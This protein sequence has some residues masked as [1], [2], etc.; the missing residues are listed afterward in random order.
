MLPDLSF[1]EWL[2]WAACASVSDFSRVFAGVSV[3]RPIQPSPVNLFLYTYP[4]LNP[5]ADV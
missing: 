1:T 5:I 3:W 2:R 4:L